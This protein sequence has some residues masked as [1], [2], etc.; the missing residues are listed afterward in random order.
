MKVG[1]IKLRK[2]VKSAPVPCQYREGS[3]R[4]IIKSINDQTAFYL[5]YKCQNV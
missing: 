4:K 2:C 5:N 1:N 3:T